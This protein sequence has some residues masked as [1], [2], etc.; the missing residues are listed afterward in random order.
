MLQTDGHILSNQKNQPVYNSSHQS[1]FAIELDKL[2][3]AYGDKI[4]VNNLTLRVP[5][6]SVYGFLGPNGA[7]KTTTIKTILGMRPLQ[8]GRARLLGFDVATQGLE[9]RKFVGYMSETNNLYAHMRVREMVETARRLSYRW[10]SQSIKHYLD[11]FQ[12][13]RDEK[14]RKL[15][16]GMKGQLALAITLAGE[17][18]LLILDEPTSG[19]DPL[20]RYEFLNQIVREVSSAG[21]TI[22]FSSH[23]LNEVEQIADTVAIVNEGK[24]VVEDDLDELKA[25][26]KAVKVAFDYPVWLHDLQVIPGV[27]RVMQEGR[28][29]R[30]LVRGDA[31]QVIA[32]LRLM[33]AR[34]V[35]LVDMNLESIFVAYLQSYP[36]ITG[37]ESEPQ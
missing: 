2:T 9:I 20:K 31:E 16:K 19:L 5:H 30:L 34:S 28:R 22:F 13:P 11:L 6:G 12:L 14:I 17:P 36:E 7:G 21:R 33:G 10:N 35:E 1:E 15:S 24:L 23:N 26:E 25:R 37:R 32:E 8:G 4:V 3:C 27:R 29:F 18:D